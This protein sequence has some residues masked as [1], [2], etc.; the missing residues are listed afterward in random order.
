[1]TGVHQW[2]EG[3]DL[4]Q[5]VETFEKNNIDLDIARDLGDQDLKF[6]NSFQLPVMI[7]CYFPIFRI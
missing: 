5:Y 2:L 4:G 3:L 1:M 7:F 6:H